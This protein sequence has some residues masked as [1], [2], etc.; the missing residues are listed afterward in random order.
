MD[1]PP[2]LYQLACERYSL[3]LPVPPEPPPPLSL[4]KKHSLVRP[5]IPSPY[6]LLDSRYYHSWPI[7]TPI[8]SMRI[9][10]FNVSGSLFYMTTSTAGTIAH[11]MDAAQIS[12]FSRSYRCT[13][14]SRQRVQNQ[15]AVPP[16]PPVWYGCHPIL[17][18]QTSN[19]VGLQHDNRRSSLH[20]WQAIR[21]I[22]WTS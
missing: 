18:K 12:Q 9:G 22:D 3:P 7:D 13:N 10:T 6:N 5:P 20:N 19:S 16:C 15:A 2:D 17:C 11:H 14:T 21:K 1:Y 8:C 4:H